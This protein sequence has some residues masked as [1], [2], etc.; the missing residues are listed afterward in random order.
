MMRTFALCAFVAGAAALKPLRA[1]EKPN[2]DR[3]RVIQTSESTRPTTSG[4][5]TTRVYTIKGTPAEVRRIQ[6][7]SEEAFRAEA[8]RQNPGQRR[9]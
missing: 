2:A 6:N 4:H 1:W 7:M 5:V 8:R 3:T 9:W